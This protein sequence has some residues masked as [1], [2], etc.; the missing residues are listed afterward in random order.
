MRRGLTLGL[1]LVAALM[2]ARFAAAT[3]TFEAPAVPVAF[4]A[5]DQTGY[6]D[7]TIT[8]SVTETLAQFQVTL[9]FDP[10]ISDITLTGADYGQLSN[11]YNTFSE[12]TYAA[13]DSPNLIDP[14][15]MAGNSGAVS[16]QVVP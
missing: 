5:N 8:D 11:P 16:A 9:L 3:I 2:P 10:G 12:G 13:G 7:V 4:G 6:F 1:L 15:V 14:Y